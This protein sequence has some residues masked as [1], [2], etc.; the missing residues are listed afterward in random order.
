MIINRSKSMEEAKVMNKSLSGFFLII[1]CFIVVFLA[2]N[3]AQSIPLVFFMISDIVQAGDFTEELATEIAQKYTAPTGT[4][5]IIVLFLSIFTIIASIIYCKF[6]EKR[7]LS[8][9]GITKK[10]AIRSYLL[11]LVIGFGVFSLIVLLNILLG[12]MKFTGFNPNIVIP[13]IIVFF[14]AFGIQ[15]ASEE[16]L[17]RGYLMNSFSV[18]HSVLISILSSS[19][20][21]ALLHIA[22][23]GISLFP[24][25][26]IFLFGVFAAFYFL[27]SNN[28][29]GVCALHSIWNFTQCIFYGITV[30]GAFKENNPILFI[31]Y[32]AS[33][34]LINGGVFG[35]EGG[36]ITTIVLL[37]GILVLFGILVCKKKIEFKSKH[38][39]TKE[40]INNV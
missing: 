10:H 39:K 3:L 15:G 28:I 23:P 6:I 21:F 35:A 20:I 26:N 34:P 5:A 7:P 25:I 13:Y 17:C 38:D 11:G 1:L 33:K 27:C 24:L 32:N 8:S 4:T 37:V 9:M 22:N 36:I 12:G 14:I 19:L 18:K 31:E 16:I 30:S 29:W 2:I 40:E